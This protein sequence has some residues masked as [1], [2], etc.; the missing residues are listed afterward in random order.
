MGKIGDEDTEK[1]DYQY[2]TTCLLESSSPSAYFPRGRIVG[3]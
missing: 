2:T 1:R 3:V